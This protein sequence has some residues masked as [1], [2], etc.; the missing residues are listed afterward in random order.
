MKRILKV[1]AIVAGGIG[2][3]LLCIALYVLIAS[4][5]VVTRT[6]AIPVTSFD[7]PSDS[8]SAGRGKHLATI[9]GCNNCHGRELQGT[10][11]LDDPKLARIHAPNLTRVV[12]EYTD[13]ELERLLRHGVKRDGRSV[14]IMPSQ[15]YSRL[16][17]QDLA[18]VIAYVRSMPERDGV[19]R[20]LTL[21]PLARIGILTGQFTPVAAQIQADGGSR[22]TPDSSDPL[23]R[24]RYLVMTA[25]TE[26]HGLDL[27][28][29]A[30]LKA[31]SLLIAAAYSSEDFAH[32]MHTG[33]G[34]GGR[35]LDLMAKAAKGRFS[36]FTDEEIAA[37]RA[38][39]D[40]F[41]RNGGKDPAMTEMTA[42]EHE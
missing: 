4:E 9:Y 23:A 15:M 27:Q 3:L 33:T 28:G 18:D 42:Q 21:R 10:V 41:V 11:F 32:L 7:A 34:M 36:S 31:P 16:T 30:F 40:A 22:Q 6:Y 1:A 5:A 12:K 26:C 17:D 19:D 24:G 13:A 25:C 2:G 35:K 37:I 20:G 8:V 14:W 38:Y 29:S 39:L